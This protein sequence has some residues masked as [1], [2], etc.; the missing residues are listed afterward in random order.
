MED[1]ET[2]FRPHYFDP[3]LKQDLLIDSG[4]QVTA[5]PPDPGDVVD[6]NVVLKAVNNTRIKTYGYKE[7]SIK[8]NRKKYSFRAIKAEV[9]S[10][11]IGWDFMKTHRLGLEWGEFGDLYLYDRV[12]QIRGLL[13]SLK[14][15]PRNI[16][17]KRNTRAERQQKRKER[18]ST[19]GRQRVRAP[20]APQRAL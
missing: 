12:A 19:A 3:I 1:S 8:I 14:K 18:G 7:I 17:T 6:K 20:C 5:F 9:D 10:P 2:D 11:V 4:S 16:K 13:N 15:Y